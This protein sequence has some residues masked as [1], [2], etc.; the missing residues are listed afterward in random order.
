MTTKDSRGS[1]G[2]N[3]VLTPKETYKYVEGVGVKKSSKK[4]F[5]TLTAG[6]L[7]GIFIALGGFAAAMA[8]NSIGNY[9][10]AKLVSGFIFPVG[11]ILVVMCGAELFTGNNLLAVALYEKRISI[12]ALA[13]N[14][15]IVYVGNLIGC[16]FIGVLV[17]YSGLLEGHEGALGG[18]AIKVASVKAGLPFMQ[19]FIRGILC[20]ILVCMAVWGSYSVKTETGKIAMLHIPVMAFIIA[21]FE[22]SVAN[23]YY[24]TVGFLAKA[25]PLFIEASHKSAEQIS[26]IDFA[27][28]AGNLLPV[29][30]GNI[31]GGV[32]FVAGLY[33]ITNRNVK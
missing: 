15:A 14:W 4:A 22:H 24:F 25:N 17:Y 1:E 29:T 26:K 16:V 33:W 2:M 5:I 6:I 19:A 8:S 27:H 7:A 9:S 30:I 31:I 11:L 23:M 12:K 10:L 18:Y 3:T 21:G 28:I 32:V 13:K 20:N